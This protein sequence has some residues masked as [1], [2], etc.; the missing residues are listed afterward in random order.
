MPPH[1]WVI[2]SHPSWDAQ[3]PVPAAGS[4]S[5]DGGLATTPLAATLL[6]LSWFPHQPS[7]LPQRTRDEPHMVNSLL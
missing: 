4:A 2:P 1:Q 3:V 5:P 7:P 6:P